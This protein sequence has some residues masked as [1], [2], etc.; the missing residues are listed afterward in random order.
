MIEIK[1]MNVT[2]GAIVMCLALKMSV[3][4]TVSVD[5]PP[6]IRMKP[7]ITTA[8]LIANK[9]KLILLNAKFLLSIL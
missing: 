7:S 2:I 5:V 4:N 9:I 1:P 6:L 3:S 8:M